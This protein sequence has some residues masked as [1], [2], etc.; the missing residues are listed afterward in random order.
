MSGVNLDPDRAEF[1]DIEFTH[2]ATTFL[3]RA[4]VVTVLAGSDLWVFVAT[5]LGED[6]VIQPNGIQVT[7]TELM[8]LPVQAAHSFCKWVIENVV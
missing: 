2:V 4:T 8:D 3:G 6:V 7:V 5:S 1:P